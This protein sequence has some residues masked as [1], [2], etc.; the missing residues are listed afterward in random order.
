LCLR[1]T[2]K[3][4]NVVSKSLNPFPLQQ[5]IIQCFTKKELA[6]LKQLAE[7]KLFFTEHSRLKTSNSYIYSLMDLYES[8]LCQFWVKQLPSIPKA[9][10]CFA[11]DK[12]RVV[13]RPAPIQLTDL[14]SAF[15]ILGIGIG[16]ATLAFLL[17]TI[18]AKWKQ[19]V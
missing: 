17:E 8:G 12:R 14:T 10:E 15:L 4:A 13:S 5:D 7:G 9:E 2:K 11:N 19:N 3:K 18:Y 16:L 1:N 6:T